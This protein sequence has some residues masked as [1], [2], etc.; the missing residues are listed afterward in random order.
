[1]HMQNVKGFYFEIIAALVLKIIKHSTKGGNDAKRVS[2]AE[3]L[4][5]HGQRLL[6][7]QNYV[8]HEVFGIL[9]PNFR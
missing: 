6:R 8:S 9:I 2:K 7:F 4:F 1:M 3:S 5:H